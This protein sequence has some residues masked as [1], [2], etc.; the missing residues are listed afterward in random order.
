[1]YSLPDR[2]LFKVAYNCVLICKHRSCGCGLFV[3]DLW[4]R[5]NSSTPNPQLQKT[6]LTR[7]LFL[8]LSKEAQLVHLGLT[9]T[10]S[11]CEPRV[12]LP[13]LTVTKEASIQL[14]NTSYRGESV[15]GAVALYC[16][17]PRDFSL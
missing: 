12:L 7:V 2:M 15:A 16:P 17:G 5:S 11:G 6:E 14:P 4:Y 13:M 8:L 9:T 10:A 1:M 3:G